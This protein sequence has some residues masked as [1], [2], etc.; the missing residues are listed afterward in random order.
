MKLYVPQRFETDL[1][2]HTKSYPVMH[3]RGCFGIVSVVVNTA[4]DPLDV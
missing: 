1:Y 4:K 3:L 2:E